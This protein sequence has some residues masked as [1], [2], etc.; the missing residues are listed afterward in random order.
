MSK[1]K[2]KPTFRTTPIVSAN[3]KMAA[4]SDVPVPSFLGE[5]HKNA[6]LLVEGGADVWDYEL[7]GLLREV[8]SL[9][10]SFITI[11]KDPRVVSGPD[12]RGVKPYFGAIA[13]AAGLTW[14]RGPRRV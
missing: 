12:R 13:M 8:E 2:K 9:A 7:A 6:L 1:S 5:R 4:L 10:P 3:P 14:A 11:T